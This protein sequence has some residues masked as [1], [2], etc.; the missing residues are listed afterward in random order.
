[1]SESIVKL[2]DYQHARLRTEMY[3]GSR[4]PHTQIVLVYPDGKPEPKEMTWVPAVFTAFRE[5]LDNALD[6]VA[7]HGHG[8]RIDVTYD[9]EKMIFSVEDNGRGIPIDY[10][11]EHKTHLATMALS[12][13]RAGRNFAERGQ[14]AGTNGIGASVVNFC[15]EYFVLDIERDGKHFKQTFKEGDD[16]L[17]FGKP[18]I[19]DKANIKRGTRVEFKLSPKVFKDLSLPE[20]FLR[21]RMYEVALCNPKIKIYY[22]GERIQAKSVEKNLFS[23]HKPI[24]IEVEEGTFKSN[25]WLIPAF[26]ETGEH[27]HT[28]VNNIPAF[29][30]GV[31]MDAFKRHFF[32]GLLTALERES[33]KRKLQPNR[34]DVADGLFIFN[35]TTMEAPNFNS[36]SKTRLNNEETAKH[37][38]AALED[39]DFFKNIIKKYSEWIDSIYERCAARTMKKDA[40]EADKDAK[41]MLREKVPGLMDATGLDRSKCI[42]FLAE[43]L[44]AISGMASVRDPEIHGGLALQGKVMNVHGATVKEVL[45]DKALRDIMN[46]IGIVPTQRVN[47]HT[48]RYTQIYVAHDMDPDGLNIGA[49]LINFFYTYWP[50]LF[51][52]DKPP[53]IHI[54]MTPFIIAEKGK[55]R[56]YWYSDNYEEFN[57]DDYKGW[58]ITRAK[59]LGT[60][61]EE[62]W[63]HSL[64]SPKLFPIVNDGK[65]QETLDLIF[66]PK[67]SDDRK[68]W[69]GL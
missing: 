20:E 27:Q 5:I 16:A 60:L 49:L 63:S 64:A 28:M 7:G 68:K 34:S 8:D 11:E 33:K 65:M 58:S 53:V 29:D 21:A 39:P 17:I 37:V 57:P 1:M 45:E 61:T 9:H 2:S 4:D 26:F 54:F 46:S 13:A 66:N 23:G 36:Q 40:S 69:I 19:K 41:K 32:S 31:H 47:R 56:K 42:L 22:N 10:S 67:R 3:L 18:T 44:S 30:G 14:V 50:E 15:S 6:E 25:F 59:G 12:E 51:D 24:H 35:I 43:G 48:M 62:D 55:Q 52:P 38:K